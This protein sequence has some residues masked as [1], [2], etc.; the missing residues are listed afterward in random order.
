M[1]FSKYEKDGQIFWQVYVGIRSRKNARARVQK[2]VTGI[3]S[4]REA[5]AL[6]KRLLRDLT[7]ELTRVEAKGARWSEVIERWA[8]HQELYPTRR[9]ASTTVQDYVAMLNNWT[10]PWLDRVA[11]EIN[12]GDGR[13]I[14][15]TAEDAGKSASL[16][17]NLKYTISQVYRWGIEERLINGVS[18]TPVQGLEL[19]RDREEK[20]PDILTSEEFGNRRAKEQKYPHIR[21]GSELYHRLPQRRTAPAQKGDLEVVPASRLKM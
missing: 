8:R 5:I 10:A 7:E 14:M 2:R 9:Y 13:D 19:T 16:R 11:S 18:E 4:E 6:E 21:F 20:R 3:A 1:A 17:K 12:R 15:R